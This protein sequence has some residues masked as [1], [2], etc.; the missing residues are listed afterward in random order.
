MESR[1]EVRAVPGRGLAGDRYFFD[2]G[3]FSATPTRG[4]EITELTLIE[5]E[6]IQYLGFEW[7]LDVEETDS[8]RNL[9]TRGV[10]L[11]DLVGVEFDVGQVRLRGAGLCEPCVSLVKSPTHRHLLRALAHKG[12][13]RAQIL[14][15]GT[16]ALGAPILVS[17][18]RR[19]AAPDAAERAGQFTHR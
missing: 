9:V 19:L 7:G 12:G 18:E 3:R 2:Q 1:S 6:V 13:L 15:E 17:A 10:S 16:I 5:H 4:R 14:S 11:N 8:R